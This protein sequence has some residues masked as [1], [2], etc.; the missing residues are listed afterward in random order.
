M[1]HFIFDFISVRNG[2]GNLPAHRFPI[3]EAKAMNGDGEPVRGHAELL[4]R[5]QVAARSCPFSQERLQTLKKSLLPRR[6]ELLAHRGES[7][8]QQGGSPTFVECR[9]RGSR[10]GWLQGKTALGRYA[11]Q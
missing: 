9:F 7:Q 2:M 3:P 4:R 1:A 11:I 10:S 8:C 6:D 5:N